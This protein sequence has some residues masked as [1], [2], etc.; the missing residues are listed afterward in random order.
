MPCGYKN[1]NEWLATRLPHLQFSY[2]QIY[3]HSC[4]DNNTKPIISRVVILSVR[5]ICCRLCGYSHLSLELRIRMHG[6]TTLRPLTLSLAW[7]CTAHRD[8]F[9]VCVHTTNY[10]KQ[11]VSATFYSLNHLSIAMTI[12]LFYVVRGLY[13]VIGTRTRLGAGRSGVRAPVWAI[14]SEPLHISLEDHPASSATG[15]GVLS[16]G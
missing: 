4:F 1:Q 6:G 7:C 10:T 2:L 12:T 3:C 16:R 11:T 15:T 14:F 5:R 8:N 13:I 9:L